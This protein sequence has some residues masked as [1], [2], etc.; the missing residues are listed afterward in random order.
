MRID[1]ANYV[2][3]LVSR[4]A[5][6]V[7]LGLIS[8][9]VLIGLTMA[10]KILRRPGLARKL[11]RLHEHVAL[12]VLGAIAVHGAALLGDRWLHAGVTALIVPFAIRYRP[13]FVGLGIIGAYLAALLGLSFYVRRRI[14]TRLWR[15]LHRA[16]LIVWLLG[17]VHTIGAGT[18]ASTVWLRMT[19]LVTGAPIVLLALLRLLHRDGQG[20]APVA[21]ATVA[22]AP[23]AA[24]PVPFAR[25]GAAAAPQLREDHL[26]AART[27]PS[28]VQ[29]TA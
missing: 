19:M 10:T 14:G 1:P 7:A 23:V 4:A 15:R 25:R 22:A 3:W 24:A 20:R 27:R 26:R 13:L 9:A 28:M 2:W 17:I 16:T 29:D 11:V 18:D 12:V 6:I 5:G 8:L 21:A